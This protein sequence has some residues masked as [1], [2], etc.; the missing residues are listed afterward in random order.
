LAACQSM[1]VSLLPG[2]AC[3]ACGQ[4]LLLAGAANCLAESDPI[5]LLHGILWKNFFQRCL[6]LMGKVGCLV[7]CNL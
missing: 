6:R 3:L 1:M 7:G 5:C 2:V 4:V